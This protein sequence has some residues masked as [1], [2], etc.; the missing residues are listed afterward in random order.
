MVIDQ[1]EYARFDGKFFSKLLAIYKF[2][3]ISDIM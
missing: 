2:I 3:R 1:N